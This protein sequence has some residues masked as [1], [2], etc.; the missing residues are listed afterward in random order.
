MAALGGLFAHP[1]Q[2][3]TAGFYRDED[4]DFDVRIVLGLA[5]TGGSDTG[6]VLAAVADVGEHYSDGWFTAWHGLAE[7]TLELADAS[8]A[9]GRTVSA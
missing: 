6:E 4:A 8:A 2:A 7:R 5:A 1:R 9:A 3:Y